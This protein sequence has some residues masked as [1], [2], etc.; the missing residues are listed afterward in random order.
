MAYS[1]GAAGTLFS[2][3][4]KINTDR[5]GFQL[6]FWH[7]GTDYTVPFGQAN[8]I[9]ARLLAVM[10]TDAEIVYATLSNNDHRKDSRFLRAALG[11]GTYVSPGE[12]PPPSVYDMPQVSVLVRFEDTEG[13]QVPRKFGPIPDEVVADEHFLD[14]IADITDGGA[15]STGAPGSGADWYENMALLIGYC[16]ANSIHVQGGHAPGAAYKWAAWT[17]AFPLRTCVKKG[18]RVFI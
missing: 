10:P 17:S 9:A 15:G 8:G 18:G 6:K 16:A 5:R 11:V 7:K 4:F 12:S 14:N 3:N 1:D 13:G 2:S